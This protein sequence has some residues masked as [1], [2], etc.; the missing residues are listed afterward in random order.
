[1]ASE[2]NLTSLRVSVRYNYKTII[3]YIR[4]NFIRRDNKGKAIR[5]DELPICYFCGSNHGLTKEHIIPRWVFNKDNELS[6]DI[7]LNG[8]LQTYNRSTIRA[9]AKCNSEL[10][11]SLEKHIQLILK[12]FKDNGRLLMRDDSS[13]IIRW[14]EIIDYKFHIMNITMKF[15][16]PMNG[17]HIPYLA[18]FPLSM[19]LQNKN[20]SPSKV[21][22]EIRKTL[23]RLSIRTKDNQVNSLVVFKTSNDNNHFFHNLN[24]FIF[25]EIAQFSIALFYFYERSFQT[26]EEARDEAMLIIRRLY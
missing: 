21:T 16:S 17:K 19:L 9:C 10:L 13:N 18:D 22:N 20:S 15:L 26:I 1:M 2:P 24:E 3:T 23:L 8:H 5:T 6:F 7:T 4:D 25:L 12:Y 11:N 14:L